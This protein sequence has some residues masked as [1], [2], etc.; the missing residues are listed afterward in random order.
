VLER[1]H[2]FARRTSVALDALPTEDVVRWYENRAPA[3]LPPAEVV[4][5]AGPSPVRFERVAGWGRAAGEPAT[6][7]PIVS[8]VLVARLF[9]DAGP[10][11][12]ACDMGGEPGKGGVLALRAGAP[13]PRWSLLAP[14]PNPAHAEVVDLDGDGLRDVVVAC[15]GGVAPSDDASGSVLL[16]RGRP[17]G[18]F[19]R[20]VLL[21]G[22]GRVADVRVAPFLREGRL[23][24][25]VAEFGWRARGRILLLENR[26]EDPGKPAF[27]PRV[28][29]DRHGTIHVPVTDLDGD[30]RPDFVACISQEHETVVAFL[31]RGGGAF[32]KRTLFA[33]PHPTYG[34]SGI[35]LVD[36]DADGRLDVL[37]TNGDTLDPPFERKAY[38]GVQWLRNPGDAT[39][40]WARR[41]V[42]PLYGVHRAV[43]ADLDGDGRTD[44]VAVA[45]LPEALF[46]VAARRDAD[47][48]VLF[49]QTASG[50]FERHA[51][52]RTTC[53]HVTC[54]LGDLTGDGRLDLL[55]GNMSF[56]PRGLRSV[57][58]WK[59]L[60]P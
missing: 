44:V 7:G 60:G 58:L 54:A 11:A 13:E 1:G 40:P 2:D 41:E 38:H 14:A 16:L 56:A 9:G 35:E 51:L 36:M 45:F 22:V 32:E 31:N 19:E 23:D 20:H 50:G 33:A 6:P 29:D 59:N 42:G 28:L 24:L 10:D 26:T 47:A 57:T 8:N 17:D 53:Q 49:R 34:S 3:T 27:E 52:E 5:A 12:I 37:Y 21:S 55:V 15:L 18:T 43:G 4:P 46:P 30:G 25:V 48:V 39:A